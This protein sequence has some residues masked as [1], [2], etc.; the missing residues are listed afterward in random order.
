M[1]QNSSYPAKVARPQ[2]SRYYARKHIFELL[3]GFCEYPVILITGPAGSGKTTLVNSYLKERKIR[4]L[5]YQVD[6]G[7]A[8]PATFFYYMRQAAKGVNQKSR[9]LLPLLTP[10]YQPGLTT[11]TIRYFEQLY[12]RM[13]RHSVIVFDNYQE[14]SISSPFHMMIRHGLSQIP[15]SIRVVLISRT[16][17]PAEL[18][19]LE[20]N[21]QMRTL[22]WRDLKLQP[23]ET[24]GIVN[25][26][27]SGPLPEKR[28]REI[29][30]LAA[31]WLA[32]V[33]LMVQKARIEDV[34]PEVFAIQAP[35]AIFD[36]FASEVFSKMDNSTQD[37]LLKTA[38]LPRMSPSLAG[39]LTGND[40][41]GWILSDLSRH[42]YF[43]ERRFSTEPV[44]S[45][46]P[47]FR[48]FLLSQAKKDLPCEDIPKLMIHAACLLERYGQV[49]DALDLILKANDWEQLVV[50]LMQHAPAMLEQGRHR[51]LEHW[52]TG[53]PENIL[54]SCPWLLFWLGTSRFP[55]EPLQSMGNFE[56]AYAKFKDLDDIVGI[57]LAWSGLVNTI[58]LGNVG[59]AKLDELMNDLEQRREA[60]DT[61]PSDEI[62]ARVASGMFAIL[63]YRNPK[64]P[65]AS[66]WGELA[67]DITR[68][69]GDADALILMMLNRGYYQFVSLG[70]LKQMEEDI[71]TLQLLAHDPGVSELG[72]LFV[73]VAEA[74]YYAVIVQHEACIRT[75]EKGLD[76]ARLSGIHMWDILLLGK[77][78]MSCQN[79]GDYVKAAHYLDLLTSYEDEP[80]P[81]LQ[82]FVQILKARQALILGDMASAVS[83][84]ERVSSLNSE[85]AIPITL[86]CDLIF[87]AQLKHKLGD[88]IRARALLDEAVSL[89]EKINSEVAFI[90]IQFLEAQIAFDQGDNDKGLAYLRDSLT[91]QAEIGYFLITCDIPAETAAV[92]A[93]ALEAG[94]EVDFVKEIIRRRRL[95]P[96]EITMTP[97]EWPWPV[98]VYTLGRFAVIRD[99]QELLFSKKAQKK[100][101]E[102][103]KAI[104][105]RGSSP[106][107]ETNIADILWPDADGDLALQ[108]CATTLHRLRKL[109]GYHEAI[110]LQNGTLMINTDICW[111]D[112]WVFEKL[113]DKADALW[114][115][116]RNEAQPMKACELTCRALDLYQGAFLAG[117]SWNTDAI[118]VNE[119]LHN[120]Y[121]NALYKLGDHLALD[122]QLK[123]V[124]EFLEHGLQI[125]DCAEECYR[126]LMICL[127][128][129]GQRAEALKVFERCRRTLDARL[130]AEPS[131]KTVALYRSLQE[132]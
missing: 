69:I 24:A 13:P 53:I 34:D 58:M 18:V 63:A 8:D 33:V 116:A 5:W 128:R 51:S 105:T 84:E 91:R 20:A 47:L 124:Q 37:F 76:L 61:L 35:E 97:K 93:K 79:V 106:M 127:Q 9:K 123:K 16:A 45:Y 89:A 15:Q 117:E 55:F 85:A 88:D 102:M 70:G 21:Q 49:D 66:F 80:R 104:I 68:G 31:G 82:G 125:D 48:T 92:F 4:C 121:F 108:T 3:D 119:H 74:N 17:P 100:P 96:D 59:Y 25:L 131:S 52:L 39:E 1:E 14:V 81:W 12:N 32:G 129:L 7:D 23:E 98:E 118:S 26:L 71:K 44:Y 57:F 95:L 30:D 64:H 11:F 113:L 112:A 40:N 72:R 109:L 41:A 111:I 90:S 78:A 107:S 36:Y 115:E 75:V 56:E 50:F 130:G 28:I 43:V 122:N 42:N 110:L 94:I 6:E 103:L 60:F 114:M 132:H 19:R 10:E 2:L 77:A 73:F 99:G 46:H 62:R 54:H 120:R 38:C 101:L 83:C 22:G 67:L 27:T 87:S 86:C 65:E 126:R 29:H